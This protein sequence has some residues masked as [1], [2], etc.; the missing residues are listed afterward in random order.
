VIRLV[1]FIFWFAVT[2]SLLKASNK[3]NGT[4]D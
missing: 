4:N 1:R 2:G 3:V